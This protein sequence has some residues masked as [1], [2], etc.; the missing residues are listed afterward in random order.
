MPFIYAHYK[1]IPTSALGGM[2][3]P[4]GQT[5]G[6]TAQK[7]HV[8]IQDRLIIFSLFASPNIENIK[9]HFCFFNTQTKKNAILII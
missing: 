9:I 7:K 1:S 8:Q 5:V 3:S 2:S 4:A 6:V